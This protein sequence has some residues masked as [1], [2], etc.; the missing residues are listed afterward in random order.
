MGKN[1]A[2]AYMYIF[3]ALAHFCI[4]CEPPSRYLVLITTIS[5]LWKSYCNSEGYVEPHIYYI[6]PQSLS[7]SPN[8]KALVG[9]GTETSSSSCQSFV[10][11]YIVDHRLAPQE[12]EEEGK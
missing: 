10:L 7:I 5:R 11:P 2:K 9:D 3:Y 8:T 1:Y 12:E 4:I 6:R